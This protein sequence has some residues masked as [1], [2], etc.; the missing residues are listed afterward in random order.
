M[1][2]LD[3]IL[4]LNLDDKPAEPVDESGEPEDEI[5][6]PDCGENLTEEWD[7]LAVT[8]IPLTTVLSS[9]WSKVCSGG[10]AGR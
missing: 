1:D 10:S 6:C 4:S 3:A 2:D 5:F 7:D 9:L 8:P